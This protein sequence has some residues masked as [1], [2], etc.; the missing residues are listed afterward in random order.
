MKIPSTLEKMKEYANDGMLEV[1]QEVTQ[2]A[3][4]YVPT[5]QSFAKAVALWI[6][7]TV[8]TIAY[9]MYNDAPLWLIA[10]EMSVG[11]MA[12]WWFAYRTQTVIEPA[13]EPE[14][15]AEPMKVEAT[16]KTLGGISKLFY[17][18]PCYEKSGRPVPDYKVWL[19][20]DAYLHGTPFSIGGM[21]PIAGRPAFEAVC[22]DFK[23][24]GLAVM[25]ATGQDVIILSRGKA[26]MREWASRDRPPI[27][28][29]RGA[30]K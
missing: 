22:E 27:L 11:S 1:N 16:V 15:P 21:S 8:A 18:A 28:I 24:R 4:R 10:A 25:D 5:D 3:T 9:V 13:P 14:P 20:F 12:V 6:P 2:F 26:I 30:T 7:T 29:E 17:V 23:K 19:I